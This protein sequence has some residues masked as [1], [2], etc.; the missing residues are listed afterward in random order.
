MYERFHRASTSTVCLVNVRSELL[1]CNEFTKL[2][3]RVQVQHLLQ[4]LVLPKVVGQQN[5]PMDIPVVQNRDTTPKNYL[6]FLYVV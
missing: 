1:F 2:A 4:V 6:L 5:G 3:S